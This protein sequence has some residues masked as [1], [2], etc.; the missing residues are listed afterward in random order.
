MIIYWAQ[1]NTEQTTL[2]ERFLQKSI[3]KTNLE[4]KVKLTAL[5]CKQQM[6]VILATVSGKARHQ[7]LTPVILATWKAHVGESQLD[8]KKLTFAN[9]GKKS[10][11]SHLDR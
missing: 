10:E 8:K 9:P 1:Q 11:R 4:C 5:W 3:L 6:Q 2:A 7:G